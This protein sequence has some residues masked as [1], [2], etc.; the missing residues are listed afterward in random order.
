MSSSSDC[1][2]VVAKTRPPKE[3]LSPN[4]LQLMCLTAQT[5]LQQVQ[6]PWQLESDN[7]DVV[8]SIFP[9]HGLVNIS[10]SSCGTPVV[11]S[12]DDFLEEASS[13]KDDITL[14]QIQKQATSKS[15]LMVVVSVIVSFHFHQVEAPTWI[16]VSAIAIR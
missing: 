9:L 11:D 7:N 12:D 3:H 13:S 10:K 4:D 5:P 15:L 16:H 2:D 8:L 1:N 6:K 14:S